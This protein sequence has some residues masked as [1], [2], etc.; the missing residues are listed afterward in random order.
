MS[1]QERKMFLTSNYHK[2]QGHL[3]LDIRR[4]AFQIDMDHPHPEMNV[5]TTFGKGRV[6][7]LPLNIKKFKVTV[8]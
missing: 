8:T 5:C 2:V 3:D 7:V 4:I 6:E 1:S